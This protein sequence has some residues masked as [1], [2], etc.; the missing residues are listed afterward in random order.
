MGG[1]AI[2]EGLEV[3]KQHLRSDL[4][5]LG[6]KSQFLRSL[7]QILLMI[8]PIFCSVT[9]GSLL[10]VENLMRSKI[11]YSSLISATLVLVPPTSIPTAYFII[12][13]TPLFSCVYLL[14]ILHRSINSP[15][16]TWNVSA[17]II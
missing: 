7:L 9:S 5:V 2:Q 14:I 13:D 11:L 17:D 12:F 8:S 6:M 4:V 3:L 10:S 1:N 15:A 16:N